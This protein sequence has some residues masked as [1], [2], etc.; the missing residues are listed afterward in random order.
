MDG[1]QIVDARMTRPLPEQ[2]RSGGAFAR[3]DRHLIALRNLVEKL[4][5]EF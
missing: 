4:V 3:D 2:A 5:R 1:H